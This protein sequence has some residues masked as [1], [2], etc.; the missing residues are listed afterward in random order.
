[1]MTWP[2]GDLPMF[3]FDFVMCD[4]PWRWEAYSDKGLH[5]SPESQYETMAFE[6][7]AA[8]P[9]GHLLAPGGV[10]LLWCTWPLMHRQIRLPKRWGLTYKTGGVWRKLTPNGKERWGTGYLLRSVC[11]PFVIATLEGSRFRGPCETNIINGIAREHSRKPE[12]AY[13]LIDRIMPGSR[14]LDMF[15]RQS[16]PGWAAWGNQATKF[17]EA[18]G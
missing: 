5:K 2:F 17:D 9:V 8:L 12:E 11:E 16:R 7:I 10:M 15:S 6:D 1:M 3:G 14:K 4:P 18:A 13:A